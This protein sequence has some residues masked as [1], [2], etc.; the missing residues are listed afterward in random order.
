MKNQSSVWSDIGYGVRKVESPSPIVRS[1]CKGCNLQKSVNHT[2]LCVTCTIAKV[3][4]E[5]RKA[6]ELFVA[7]RKSIAE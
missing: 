5:A 2:G 7:L 4:L 3:S 1:R 6:T